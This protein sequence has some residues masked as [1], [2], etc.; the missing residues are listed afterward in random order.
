MVSVL[1]GLAAKETR[2]S[3]AQVIIMI[4]IYKPLRLVQGKKKVL[5]DK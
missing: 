2:L 1:G 5:A 3:L 4:S